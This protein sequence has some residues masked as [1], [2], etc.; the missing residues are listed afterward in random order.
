[1]IRDDMVN[2]LREN[3]DIWKYRIPQMDGLESDGE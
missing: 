2:S 3:V 1:M